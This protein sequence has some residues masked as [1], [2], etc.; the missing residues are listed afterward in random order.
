MSGAHKG[1]DHA[2][3]GD[4]EALRDSVHRFARRHIE[5]IA[6]E[7]DQSNE[8]PRA[9][10]PLLGELGVHGVGLGEREY[11]AHEL[12]ESTV[13]AMRKVSSFFPL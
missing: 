9:L 2:L 7:I 10:W 5:P 4:I 11:L 1:L 12:G 3:G 8:F 13:D 6:R